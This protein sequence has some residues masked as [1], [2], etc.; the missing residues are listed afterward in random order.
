MNK[1]M[2]RV[3]IVGFGI[4]GSGVASI[5]REHQSKGANIELVKVLTRSKTGKYAQP[6]YEANPEIFV[7]ELQDI[8]NDTDVDVIVETVGGLSFAKTVIE[9]AFAHGKHVVT[10]NKDLL[11]CAGEEL[12]A[13][14]QK[15]QKQFIFEASIAGA[16]P[17]VRL[18]QNYLSLQD[19]TALSGIINGTTNYI[20]SEMDINN[21]AFDA[22]LKDAQEKGFAEQDPTNDIKG[23]DARYKLVILC[24]LLTGQWLSVDAITVDGIDTL[25]LPDFDYAVRMKR[26]IKLVASLKREGNQLHAFVLPLM[27]PEDKPLAKVTGSTNIVTIQGTYSDDISIEGKGAGSFPTA[28]AIV[29]DLYKSQDVVSYTKGSESSPYELCAFDE[30]HFKHTLRFEVIDCP[31]IVGNVGAILAKYGISIYALEQLPQYHIHEGN[32]D[33]VIFTFTLDA[34]KEGTVQKAI[35]EINA[36]PYMA[37]P[38]FVLRELC[39]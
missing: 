37:K 11:A 20:L 10:A 33:S 32:T 27:I 13:L 12:M 28:S 1:Q 38:V 21:V 8:L 18:L 39:D 16:I 30:H 34:C 17:V 14:A 26:K 5:I 24:Y 29:A 2:I 31:G 4:V 9:Q 7:D 6:F 23:Y 25:E 15:A 3:A 19:V 36:E 22:A 35:H